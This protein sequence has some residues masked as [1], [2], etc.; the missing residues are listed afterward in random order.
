[1]CA[2]CGESSWTNL[3]YNISVNSDYKCKI[4][5]SVFAKT[6][7]NDLTKFYSIGPPLTCIARSSLH[8]KLS[9]SLRAARVRKKSLDQT[10]LNLNLLDL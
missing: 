3:K 1:M 7:I 2:R 5:Y 10:K 4:F 6:V 8:L 9:A